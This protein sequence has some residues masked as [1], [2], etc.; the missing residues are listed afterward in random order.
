MKLTEQRKN[1]I[2]IAIQYLVETSDKN[3][4]DFLNSGK[5]DVNR[6]D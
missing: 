2:T 4:C 3:I 6:G 1:A 5:L